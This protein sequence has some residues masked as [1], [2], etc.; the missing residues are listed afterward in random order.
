MAKQ[1]KSIARMDRPKNMDT[2]AGIDG[3]AAVLIDDRRFD[4]DFDFERPKST[5]LGDTEDQRQET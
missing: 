5:S 2:L 4:R 3:V 1:L